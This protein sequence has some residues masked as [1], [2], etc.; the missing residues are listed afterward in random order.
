MAPSYGTAAKTVLTVALL[1]AVP[2]HFSKIM[3]SQEIDGFRLTDAV[4]PLKYSLRL[5]PD[6]DTG[7]FEGHEQVD[8]VLHQPQSLLQLHSVS[9]QIVRVSV[10]DSEGLEVALNGFSVE[11]DKQKLRILPG[12]TLGA[13]TYK[14]SIDFKG[15]LNN[16]I[17]GFY[18]ST[19]KTAN[20]T[21]RF[22]FKSRCELITLNL[23]MCY[24]V[25]NFADNINS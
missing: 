1:S 3:S 16:R 19:Y 6:L 5:H 13:G 10:R 2:A 23:F 21:R 4:V 9:L 14:L 24:V 18:R 11:P 22:S 7:L 25:K 12:K 15:D 17:I 8:V 20:G